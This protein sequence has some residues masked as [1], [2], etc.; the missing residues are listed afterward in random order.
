[1]PKKNKK[2]IKPVFNDNTPNVKFQYDV[3]GS[4]ERSKRVRYS[5]VFDTNKKK[6]TK[7]KK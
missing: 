5:Q 3:K 2:Y 1:M 7:K 4:V 6:E